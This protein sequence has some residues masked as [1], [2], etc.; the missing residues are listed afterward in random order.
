[1]RTALFLLPGIPLALSS[2]G[3]GGA[4]LETDNVQA[5]WFPNGSKTAIVLEGESEPVSERETRHSPSGMTLLYHSLGEGRGTLEV[6]GGFPET[7]T[8]TYSQSAASAV[9]HFKTSS[10]EV[11]LNDVIRLDADGKTAS[12]NRWS[13][14]ERDTAL[15]R[16]GT[17]GTM[18]TKNT[19]PCPF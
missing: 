12:L 18:T 16:T 15:F 19:I 7:A 6:T 2:C 4:T 10:R 17:S 14:Q 8:V 13:C 5:E 9:L 1:M 11:L 3:R